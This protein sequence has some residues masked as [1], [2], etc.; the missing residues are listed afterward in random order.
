MAVCPAQSEE[1]AIPG[2]EAMSVESM[3][4][5]ASYWQ[6]GAYIFKIFN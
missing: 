1:A 3:E 5:E 6:M 4:V 2:E